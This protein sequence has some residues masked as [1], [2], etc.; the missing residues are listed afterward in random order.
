MDMT[1]AIAFLA[2]L[3]VLIGFGVLVSWTSPADAEPKTKNGGTQS[4][5]HSRPDQ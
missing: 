2:Y 1:L 4:G 5:H 3:V